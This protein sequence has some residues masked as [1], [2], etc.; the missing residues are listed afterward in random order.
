VRVVSVNAFPDGGFEAYRDPRM[1]LAVRP[2][3]DRLRPEVVH[4]GS[5]AGLSTGLVG[6]ARRSSPVVLTL[7]DFW[8]VCPLGQLVTLSLEVCPGPA[9]R[10]CLGCVG[11]QVATRRPA[12]RGLGRRLPL[13]APLGR[14]AA[15]VSTEAADR[16]GERGEEMRSVLR[17]ADRVLAPSRSLRDRLASLGIEG[18]VYLP[19]GLPTSR[20]AP[21][22]PDADGRVR[23]GFL[24]AA[25][26]SKGVHVLAEAFCRLGDP[27]ALLRIH[28]GFPSYHGDIGYEARI[29][30]VLG[31]AAK[32]ALRGP[33]AHADL[34][35]V[36]AG[37]D[38]VVVPSL[39]EENAPLVVL[40]AFRAR[41]PL[42]VSDH[43]GLAELV[44]EGV[45]GLR[46]PPGDAAAL[47]AALRRLLDSPRLREQL[48]RTPPHVPQMEE[49]TAALETVY[50]EALE[51]HRARPG[52][53]GV[54][55][56]DH[57]RPEDA[58][59]AAA[60]ALDP[61]LE[62]RVVIVENGSPGRTVRP[63]PWEVVVLPVNLGF[64]G[65]ANAG[66]LRLRAL[67]CDRF[68]LLNND[69]RLEPGALRQMAEALADDRLGAVGPV[70]LRE[71]DGRVE[72]RGIRVDAGWGRVRL[73]GHGEAP[74]AR[75]TIT[76]VG[77]LSGVALMM[78]LAALEQ[79]GPFDEAY[80]HGFEDV[81]W[82]ARLAREGLGRAV[83][84]GARVRHGGARTLGREAPARLYYAARNHLRAA[85]RLL[86]RSGAGLWTRRLGIA[87]MNLAHALRQQDVPRSP[88]VRAVL[89]GTRDAW[90]GRAGRWD[91]S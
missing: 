1:T 83:V 18:V 89:A 82:C 41:R 50:A 57:G 40:E 34:P 12:L 32:D 11:E 53:V 21:L 65:A 44:R 58:A 81:E 25:I 69:A 36:L 63:G 45:D 55:V 16:I 7:H 85:E 79:V 68:L 24:G 38:V 67:G 54:V 77:A 26:P 84:L 35:Q 49:H 28:G 86:P 6:E 80:F 59:A 61:T 14:L 74:E 48:G 23:F 8:P 70:V 88:A 72:S 39:W 31:A 37:I 3:L 76:P 13:L 66:L 19:H 9:P 43:G 33:Y 78:S 30:S 46:V 71:G 52:R 47:A 22:Q 5:L 27:R 56:P 91:L 64:A 51:R 62:V 2:L 87:G 42:L 75:S 29:R 4:V 73:L 15:R 17:G 10:R 60:S 90:R 20:P